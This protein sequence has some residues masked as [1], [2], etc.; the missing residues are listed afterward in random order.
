MV[1]LKAFDE[2]GRHGFLNNTVYFVHW[3]ELSTSK[4]GVALSGGLHAHFQQKDIEKKE[5]LTELSQ[6]ANLTELEG[7]NFFFI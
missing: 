6:D 4:K 7:R 5:N 2:L 3:G 1:Y